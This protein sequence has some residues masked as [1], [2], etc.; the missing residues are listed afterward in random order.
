[1]LIS[2]LEI[3]VCRWTTELI[4]HN[5]Q[6]LE[7]YFNKDRLCLKCSSPPSVGLQTLIWLQEWIQVDSSSGLW[8]LRGP[9]GMSRDV[10]NQT[11]QI[12]AKLV[13]LA[14]L[15]NVH[16]ISY[17][18][19]RVSPGGTGNMQALTSLLY[20]LLRQIII[21]VPLQLHLANNIDFSEHR[22]Q[23]LDG[24]AERW[25]PAISIL[26]DLMALIPQTEKTYCILDGFNWVDKVENRELVEELL[27]IFQ[28]ARLN[29]LFATT[30]RSECLVRTIKGKR[31]LDIQFVPG[32]QV[33]LGQSGRGIW[34]ARKT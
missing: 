32:G 24:T 9:P 12:S 11:T 19:P 23:Q 28:E 8:W 17:F 25:I 14:A 21:L 29:V 3:A 16:M 18:C 13:E 27:K 6:T 30:G 26:R 1:M 34:G 4:G 31:N 5:S 10:D 7:I 33:D 2:T 15:E 22:F 20:A